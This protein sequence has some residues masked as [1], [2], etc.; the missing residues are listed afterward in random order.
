MYN[1]SIS[2]LCMEKLSTDDWE[3]QFNITC[4]LVMLFLYFK[5][6][7]YLTETISDREDAVISFREYKII[8]KE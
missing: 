3:D 5:K 7:N 1:E 2:K 4:S 6:E 8:R